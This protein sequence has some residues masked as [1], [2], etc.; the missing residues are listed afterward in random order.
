MIV[1]N[2]DKGTAYITWKNE[3][4]EYIKLSEISTPWEPMVDGSWMRVSDNKIHHILPLKQ[5]LELVHFSFVFNLHNEDLEMIRNIKTNNFKIRKKYAEKRDQSG[6]LRVSAYLPIWPIWV[7]TTRPMVIEGLEP[8]FSVERVYM[9]INGEFYRFPYGNVN[10]S[11]GMCFGSG[12]TNSFKSIDQMWVSIITTPFNTDYQFNVRAN[13]IT[14]INR[15]QTVSSINRRSA[16]AHITINVPTFNLE[17]ISVRLAAKAYDH[18]SFLDA[19]YYLTNIKEFD[20]LAPLDVFYKLP[21]K[22][23]EEKKK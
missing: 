12:N 11:D 7:K 18:L 3:I 8:K 23:W 19:L 16:M 2:P 15:R 4:Q 5:E 10:G 20:D 13:R 6:L 9:N 17:E 1:E 21:H 22:P 14:V